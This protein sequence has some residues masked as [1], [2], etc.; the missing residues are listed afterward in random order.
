VT[1]LVGTTTI[2]CAT[3]I[4]LT[5]NTETD[6]A[7]RLGIGIITSVVGAAVFGFATTAFGHILQRRFEESTLL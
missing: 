4:S 2:H 1:S 3:C 6:S 5:E 7:T